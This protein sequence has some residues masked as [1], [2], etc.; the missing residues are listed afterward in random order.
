MRSS[1]PLCYVG[2]AIS[3][4][5][6]GVGANEAGMVGP[7][8]V[9]GVEPGAAAAIAVLVR[10]VASMLAVLVALAAYSAARR[11]FLELSSLAGIR[12]RGAGGAQ[13]A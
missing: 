10:T 11:R 5:P 3:L 2:A 7:L 4:R 13:T 6:G 8:V 1:F 9:V 12:R